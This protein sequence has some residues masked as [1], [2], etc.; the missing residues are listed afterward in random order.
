[1][2]SKQNYPIQQLYGSVAH[3]D[4]WQ[5]IG[6]G[7]TA[8]VVV[9]IFD[10]YGKL[11]KLNHSITIGANQRSITEILASAPS[12]SEA[13][14]MRIRSMTAAVY[15]APLRATAVDPST[16]TVT[17]GWPLQPGDVLGPHADS[18]HVIHSMGIGP[19][20]PVLNLPLNV[21]TQAV[22]T[23]VLRALGATNWTS[24]VSVRRG[25][26]GVSITNHS[27]TLY[28]YAMMVPAGASVAVWGTL[29]ATQNV[30]QISPRSTLYMDAGT[31]ID[32]ALV[33][34]T[35][36]TDAATVMEVS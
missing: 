20:A 35:V 26:R 33:R 1:M 12:V 18:G 36:S 15:G 3:L 10:R 31:F 29:S 25:R 9:D 23:T 22:S 28:L 27:T 17:T 5:F 24:T 19:A 14:S 34:D 21:E 30:R 32:V 13:W 8:A 4:D 7:S 16:L 6:S 2:G 11:I